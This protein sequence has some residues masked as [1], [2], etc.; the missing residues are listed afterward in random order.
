MINRQDKRYVKRKVESV[1]ELVSD[2][3]ERFTEA[4]FDETDN[5]SYLELFKEFNEEYKAKATFLN[6]K[7]DSKLQANV[8]GFYVAFYPIEAN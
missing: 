2:I 4:L 6:K 5:R 8:Y 7:N 3:T 1:Q